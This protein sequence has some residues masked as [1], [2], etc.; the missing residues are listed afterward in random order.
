MGKALHGVW[1]S[2]SLNGVH[3]FITATYRLVEGPKLKEEDLSRIEYWATIHA[4]GAHNMTG[5]RRY[6]RIAAK[7]KFDLDRQY[8][9]GNVWSV[10]IVKN[11]YLV[12]A[13][14]LE[15]NDSRVEFSRLNG[16]HFI[17]W[18]GGQ[19][20]DD[21]GRNARYMSSGAE[22]DDED[23]SEHSF[24]E[25]NGGGDGRGSRARGRRSDR[26]GGQSRRIS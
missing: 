16:G 20:I 2:M 4:I 15:D 6:N 8:G 21:S 10:V 13:K 12:K 17:V 14:A 1:L 26:G 9:N 19:N 11:R 18:R 24:R 5:F 3:Y 7:L 23:T 22:K 25:Y